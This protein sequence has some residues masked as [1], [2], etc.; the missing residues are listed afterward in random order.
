MGLIYIIT[1]EINGKQY[2]GQTVRDLDKRIWQHEND[3]RGKNTK[4]H[5]HRAIRKYGMENF[6]Y[7]GIHVDDSLLNEFEQQKIKELNTFNNGYN[8]TTGGDSD[9][10][11]SAETRSKMRR[12]HKDISGENHPMFGIKG[13]DNPRYGQKHSKKARKRMSEAQI[14]GKSWKAKH[15]IITTPDRREVYVCGLVQYCKNNNLTVNL[16]YAVVKNKQTHH[17]GYKVRKATPEEIKSC[18]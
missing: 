15:Y 11:V 6:S 17:K 5:I 7:Y 18:Q 2:V 10:T 16:M 8:L 3:A 1:N 9:Y 13:E 4:Y 14:G 12:S